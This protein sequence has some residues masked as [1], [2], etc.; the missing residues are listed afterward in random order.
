MDLS[1]RKQVDL[2]LSVESESDID[3]LINFK[4][5]EKWID[6]VD[7]GFVIGFRSVYVR[8]W[9]TAS[10]IIRF[11]LKKFLKSGFL[12]DYFL[13]LIE[14]HEWN[15]EIKDQYLFYRKDG[16]GMKERKIYLPHAKKYID[17]SY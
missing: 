5:K 3:K 11:L 13:V 2:W 14:E 16:T 8:K 12:P 1:R 10:C 7:G 17:S 9:E 4:E 15:C 6:P